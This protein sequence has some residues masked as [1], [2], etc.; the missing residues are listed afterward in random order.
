[1]SFDKDAFLGNTK[2]IFS[3]N[4]VKSVKALSNPD[5]GNIFRTGRTAAKKAQA[6][7]SLLIEK[8]RQRE[9]TKLSEETDEIARRKALTKSGKGGR[10]SLIKTS[11]TGATNLGGTT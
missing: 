11:E 2:D 3:L 6:K 9:E 5:P 4:P 8:Q 10:Q 1:M 7:Q